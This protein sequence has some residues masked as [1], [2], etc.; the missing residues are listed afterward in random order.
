MVEKDCRR[1]QQVRLPLWR[2]RVAVLVGMAILVAGLSTDGA[3][4]AAVPPVRQRTPGTVTADAL[5]TVQINGVVW[6]QVMIGNVVYAGGEFTAAR[7]AGAPAGTQETPRGN[8]LAYDI[9]TGELVKTFRPGAFNGKIKALAASRDGKTLF[10]GGGFTKIGKSDRS[11]FAALNSLTGGLRSIKPSFNGRINALAVDSKTVF[12]AGTFSSVN[13]Q[14]RGRLAAVSTTGG[15]LTSWK[16]SANEEVHALVLTPRSK[17]L[18]VGGMFTK[19]NSTTARGSGAVSPT[20]GKTKT[21]KV[22]RVVK[23]G[24][25]QSS[26]ILSLATD[27]DTVYGTGFSSGTGN[28]EGVYAASVKDGTIR[29]LQDCHGDTYGVAP[30]GDV[31]YSVGHAHY[32]SNIGGFSDTNDSSRLRTMWYRALAVSKKAAGTVA[33]NG[34]TSVK[35]YTDFAGQPAPALVNW[36]PELTAGN[37]TG[38]TQAAWSVVGN[39][40]YIS[41]GGEFPSVNGANQQGLVRMAIPR[42]AA[43]GVGPTGGASGLALSADIVDPETIRLN[44]RELW[45][46]D[47][48]T[49]TYTVRRNDIVI[50]KQTVSVPFWKRSVRSF[51]DTNVAAEESSI[52]TYQVTVSDR[53]GNTVVSSPVHIAKPPAAPPQGPPLSSPAPT[54]PIITPSGEP[55]VS[56]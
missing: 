56:R 34:Q 44:W 43:N 26:A 7:P 19:L 14:P 18:V 27:G 21:W 42:F 49:L 2:G 39:S 13:G 46:R 53:D 45:D 24:G 52:L 36:F 6:T 15:R 20:T 1:P 38:M 35:T 5:P 25:K 31:V 40:R 17:L 28:F 41:L 10:V 16:S 11:R 47:D 29:W 12:A 48:L 30:I 9:T 23:N 33:T 22:N 54:L 37:Y 32:C 55:S 50:D 3:A 51:S 4:G 8:L